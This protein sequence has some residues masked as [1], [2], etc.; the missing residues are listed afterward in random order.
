MTRIDVRWMIRRDMPSVLAIEE[1]SWHH[2]VCRQATRILRQDDFIAWLRQRNC[3]GMV[4]EQEEQV[5]GAMV[6]ELHSGSIHLV[7][8]A[9][10]PEHRRRDIGTAMIDKI[11]SKLS[12]QR[13]RKLVINVD[14]FNLGAQLFLRSL[15]IP[16][17]Q[18]YTSIC[19]GTRQYA[20]DIYEFVWRH[21]SAPAA[22][23]SRGE[24]R[25]AEPL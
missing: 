22:L 16:C 14:E 1:A 9:V 2:D 3:I 5:V 18:T 15:H 4:A 12:S 10:H 19:E 23:I 24:T 7:Y 25:K 8:M 13:R 20:P 17:V 11:R 6:Y 21:N